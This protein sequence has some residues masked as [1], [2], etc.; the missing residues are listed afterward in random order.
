[1]GDGPH[2]ED[3]ATEWSVHALAMDSAGRADAL[4]TQHRP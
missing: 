3:A 2:L 4:T 1:M